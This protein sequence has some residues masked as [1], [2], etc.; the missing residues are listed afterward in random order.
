VRKV[1]DEANP[2]VQ[3]FPAAF[4]RADRGSREQVGAPCPE[5]HP[6]GEREPI[7]LSCASAA[8]HA[9]EQVAL[10]EVVRPA[11]ERG[12]ARL[13]REDI[14]QPREGLEEA[15]IDAAVLAKRGEARL[16]RVEEV[17]ERLTDSPLVLLVRS[18]G[19]GGIV[20]VLIRG[21]AQIEA[22][23]RDGPEEVHE[24]VVEAVGGI[25]GTGPPQH[26]RPGPV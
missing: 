22:D 12:C 23:E 21:F 5:F 20:L 9:L 14:E 15:S 4:C 7:R 24:A 8:Q 25:V 1:G 11:Q 18:Y 17:L 16:R 13:V 6:I 3:R 10:V 19:V 2:V 26:V